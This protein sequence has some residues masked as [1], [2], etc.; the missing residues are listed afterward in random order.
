MS[1]TRS[2]P[3]ASAVYCTGV[4]LLVDENV[5]DGLIQQI[6]DLFP[7]SAHIKSI[8]L[9]EAEDCTVWDWTKRHQFTIVSKTLIS[10]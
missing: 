9:Q 1:G 7:G 5:S 3:G 10:T 2:G 6:A 8:G 4:K